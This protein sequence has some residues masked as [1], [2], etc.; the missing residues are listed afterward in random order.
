ML[1]QSLAYIEGWRIVSAIY[2]VEHI[3][4]IRNGR[5]ACRE[6]CSAQH[7][8][9]IGKTAANMIW[10]NMCRSDAVVTLKI[11]NQILIKTSHKTDY[12][13]EFSLH[14]FD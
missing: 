14:D 3:K 1:G 10:W 6:H 4:T 2:N 8:L 5:R 7:L 9:F 11:Q 12:F 13:K